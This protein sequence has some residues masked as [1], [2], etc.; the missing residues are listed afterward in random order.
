M[1]SRYNPWSLLIILSSTKLH[2]LVLQIIVLKYKYM[3]CPHEYTYLKSYGL[4]SISCTGFVKFMGYKYLLLAAHSVTDLLVCRSRG[5]G[6]DMTMIVII[7]G[8]MSRSSSRW[9][10]HFHSY[11]LTIYVHLY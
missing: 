9:D 10:Y 6:R 1:I 2:C 5:W 4:D 7:M 11:V 8:P 3:T